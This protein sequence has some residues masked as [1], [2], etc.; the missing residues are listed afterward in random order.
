VLNLPSFLFSI[1][2]LF[3]FLCF[4]VFFTFFVGRCP[5]PRKGSQ[6]LDPVLAGGRI[7]FIATVEALGRLGEMGDGWGSWIFWKEVG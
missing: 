4:V 1:S 7:V 6:P 5:T 2:L 3:Y